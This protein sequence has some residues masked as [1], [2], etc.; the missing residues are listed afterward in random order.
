V[1]AFS[2]ERVLAP[3]AVVRALNG[4]LPRAIRVRAAEEVP[5]SFHPRF[6]AR[7]KTYRYRI[8]N[9]DVMSP[10]ARRYAWHVAA[11]LDV[12]AMK[13]AARVLEGTHDF[14]AFQSVGS[15]AKTTVR[16]VV[17]SR[18]ADGGLRTDDGIEAA[19]DGV[20]SSVQSAIGN[21]RSAMIVYEVS[22]TGFLRH[23]VRAIVGS[24][25]EIGRGRRSASWMERVLASRDRAQAGPTAPPEGLF[26][27][28]VNYG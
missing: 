16:T 26:L 20:E 23:M 13:A 17:S 2:L 3:D 9:A 5:A 19:T 27:V 18:I 8:C 25:V 4:R 10:F 28:R 11:S 21:P 14:A 1:A 6:A 15:E 22:A 24:L 12:D 7:D